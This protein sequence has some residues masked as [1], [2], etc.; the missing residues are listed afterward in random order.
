MNRYVPF[1]I[2]GT[3]EPDGTSEYSEEEAEAIIGQYG[4]IVQKTEWKTYMDGKGEMTHGYTEF[5]GEGYQN[6]T[7]TFMTFSDFNCFAEAAG[8]PTV[9]SDHQFYILR[10]MTFQADFSDAVLTRNGMTCTF[11]GI[12]ENYPRAAFVYFIIL[13]PDEMAKGMTVENE[14]VGFHLKEAPTDA[15]SLRK[16]L[17]YQEREEVS[18]GEWDTYERCDY[19]IKEYSRIQNNSTSAIL[20]V[21]ALYAAAVF[22]FLS[23]AILALKTLAGMSEDQKK[24][25]ILFRLGTG[26]KEER[27]ALFRQIF[28]FFFLPFGIPFLLSVPTA[29]ICAELMKTAGYPELVA[30]AYRTAGGIAAVLLGIYVLYFAAT[31]LIAKRNV[32]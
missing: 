7:D 4:E 29:M 25:Q 2:I 31:Y 12:L 28:S 5:T 20:V 26:E 14:F 19:R 17:T 6:L 18:E 22:V 23:M 30:G 13:I 10:D 15:A 3:L 11:G 8:Y 16:D 24:Y 1:D 32:L 9:S 27:R 21:G